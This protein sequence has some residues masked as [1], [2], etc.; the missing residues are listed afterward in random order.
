MS[1][2]L[3]RL[4]GY[5]PPD[6]TVDSQRVIS[7]DIWDA[8][9]E[10]TRL[11]NE[12]S[13]TEARLNAADKEIADLQAALAEKEKEHKRLKNLV[14]VFEKLEEHVQWSKFYLYCTEMFSNLEG[15]VVADPSEVMRWLLSKNEENNDIYWICQLAED[16]FKGRIV[17]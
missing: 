13:D 11:R 4:K 17:T 16:Y 6:R 5:N 8:V 14:S 2:I 1:D 3:E 10:I 7:Q 15:D 9:A 12:L